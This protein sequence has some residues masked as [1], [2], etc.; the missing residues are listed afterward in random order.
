MQL[1]YRYDVVSHAKASPVTGQLEKHV[2]LEQLLRGTGLEAVYS[3]DN[4]ATIR[5]ISVGEKANPGAKAATSDKPSPTDS[6]PTTSTAPD[7]S[8]RYLRLAQTTATAP[9]SDTHNN[10]FGEITVTRIRATST[11]A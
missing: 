11:T 3:N 8:P 2:A 7:P 4:T 6:P 5:P 9:T 1:L 10:D